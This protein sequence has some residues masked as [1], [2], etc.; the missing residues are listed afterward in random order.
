MSVIITTAQSDADVLGI[1]AL[2]RANLRKNL[3]AD[4]Q[5]AQGFLTVEHNPAVLTR[6]N[7]AAPSIIAKDGDCVVGYAL[8]MLSDFRNDVPELTPLFSFIDTLTYQGNALSTYDYYVMGQVCVAD[9]YRGQQLFDR[10]YERHR[11]LYARQY[12]LLVT[13]ISQRNTRSLRAHSRVGFEPLHAFHDPTL[14]ETWV[15]VV[16]DWQK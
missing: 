5:T 9:G 16:W 6:M 15:V 1:L 3:L 14:G 4:V 12:R 13:D 2:Q 7:Q 11:E 8:T 10:M